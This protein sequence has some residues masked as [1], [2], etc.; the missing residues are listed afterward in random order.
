[1]SERF[2]W[3]EIPEEHEP[4][5]TDRQKTPEM[6]MGKRCPECDWLD[7]E[8]ARQLTQ[9]RAAA[10]YFEEAAVASGAPGLVANW[11]MG[12][13]TRYLKGDNREISDSPVSPENLAAL[14]KLVEDGTISGKIAKEVF[15]KMYAAGRPPG[16]IIEEEGLR[17]ISDS[18]AIENLVDEVIA[19]HPSEVEAFQ[20]GK[21]GLI[22]FFVGQVMKAS[23][24]QANPKMVNELLRGKLEEK[25]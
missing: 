5:V 25:P 9:T 22:G 2:E 17:Q 21:Q 8:T 23:K 13:L 18:S 3:L 14:V 7:E 15:S 10:D 4:P 6:V 20:G 1:M 12:D 11:M 16:Q 19:S 24:G